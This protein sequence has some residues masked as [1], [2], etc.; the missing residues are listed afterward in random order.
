MQDDS[1]SDGEGGGGA[2]LTTRVT[3]PA[4]STQ[5]WSKFLCNVCE[6]KTGWLLKITGKDGVVH[7][8]RL[9]E[10]CEA[11]SKNTSSKKLD[12]DNA[13]FADD[14]C[15]AILACTFGACV[16]EFTCVSLCLPP[17]LPPFSTSLPHCL[18][19]M[20]ARYPEH[21]HAIATVY[22]CRTFPC[23]FQQMLTYPTDADV[24]TLRRCCGATR[25]YGSW[26]CSTAQSPTQDAQSCAM[27]SRI[28][29]PLSG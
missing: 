28:H 13:A 20:H 21:K 11:M 19:I 5:N 29:P 25:H 23:T 17:P 1:N 26:T 27:P 15:D 12:L 3:V 4:K 16:A 9:K 24:C 6:S 18:S 8:D 10:L 14:G 22:L 7:P 2:K